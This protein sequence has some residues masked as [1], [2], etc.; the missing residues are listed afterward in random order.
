MRIELSGSTPPADQIADQ[1]RGSISSGQLLP[2]ERLPSV[3]QLARDLAVAPG[4]VAKAYRSLEAGGFVTARPGGATRV[5][6]EASPASERVLSA[7]RTL[8]AE[9][10]RAELSADDAVRILRAVWGS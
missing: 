7:A 5:S 6:P 4:T 2:D 8:S 1:L 9:C 10:A 3:R